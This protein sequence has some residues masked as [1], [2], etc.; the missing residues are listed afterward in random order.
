ME[1]TAVIYLKSCP[2]CRGDMMVE[3]MLGEVEL[4]CL[5]CGYRSPLPAKGSLPAREPVLAAK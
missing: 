2:R 5:Q 1:V 4:V 3:A